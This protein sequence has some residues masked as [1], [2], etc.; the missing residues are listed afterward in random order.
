MNIAFIDLVQQQAQI[1][2]KIDAGL[3]A[4]LNHGAYIMGPEVGALESR[5][6]EWTKTTH[7]ISCSSGTDALLLALRGLELQPGKGVIVPSFTFAASAEELG[8]RRL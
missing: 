5:L 1:R 8:R 3:A 2:D 7:N 4:V 6:G